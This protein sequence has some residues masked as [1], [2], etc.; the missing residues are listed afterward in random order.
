M[1]TQLPKTEVLMDIAHEIKATQ[2]GDINVVVTTHRGEPVGLVITSFRHEK[3][4][5]NSV[6][7]ERILQTFKQMV[8]TKQTGQLTFTVVFHEG[9]VKE[10][11][12]QLYD[13]KTYQVDP[14][15]KL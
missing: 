2:F 9:M 3:F 7:L 15:H 12:N 13:K 11:I 4:S 14:K 1:I 5:E 8:D 10:V 6:A